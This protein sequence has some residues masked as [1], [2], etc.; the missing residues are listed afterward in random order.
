MKLQKSISILLYSSAVLHQ[1]Q[2][3]LFPTSPDV[4]PDLNKLA[5]SQSGTLLSIGLDIRNPKSLSRLYID[6][7]QLELQST[8][9]SNVLQCIPLPGANGATPQFSTGPLHLNTKSEGSFISIHGKQTMTIEN[10]AWEMLW[11]ADRPTGSIVCGFH[12]PQPC[13]RNDAVLPSGEIFLNFRV[14]TPKGL[15]IAR[16]DQ[17]TNERRTAKYLAEQRDALEKLNTTS[18][19]LMK[20][21]FLRDAVAANEQ[22]SFCGTDRYDFVPSEDEDVVTVG[23]GLLVSKEGSI[24][25]QAK[26][27]TLLGKKDINVFLGRAF[28]KE[29]I[30]EFKAP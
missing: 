11:V 25:T 3:F 17:M 1:T 13:I 19:P 7:L 10:Q 12:L 6:N 29:L 30:P 28:L 2:G 20:A 21:K 24:W 16:N 15:H 5:Q 18:N 26:E 14:W 22:L 9:P 8:A 27:Q 23:D 4:H